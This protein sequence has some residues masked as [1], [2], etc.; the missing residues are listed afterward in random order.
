[1]PLPAVAR[2]WPISRRH[3]VVASSLRLNQATH[4][5]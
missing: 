1:M 4:P 5:E 3:T 2:E